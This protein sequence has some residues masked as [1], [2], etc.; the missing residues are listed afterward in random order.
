MA[1]KPVRR[2]QLISPFGVGA[3]IDFPHDEALMTAGLEAWPYAAEPCPPDWKIDEERLQERLG[4]DHFRLPPD[5]RADDTDGRYRLQQIPFVRFPRWHYCPAAGCGLM[6][7]RPLFG[8][9]IP[10]CGSKAHR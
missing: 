2:A 9:G 5:Y 8:A 10:T 6:V 3:M 4:V 7:K 1:H